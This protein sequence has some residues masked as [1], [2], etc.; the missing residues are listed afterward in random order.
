MIGNLAHSTN[1]TRRNESA[2]QRRH[3]PFRTNPAGLQLMEYAASQHQPDHASPGSP[4][5]QTNQ[6]WLQN[7]LEWKVNNKNIW[8]LYYFNIKTL[9]K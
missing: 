6:A 9:N 4:Q 2:H 7:R 3:S 1:P 8:K 5:Y